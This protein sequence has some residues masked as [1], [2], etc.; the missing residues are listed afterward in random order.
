[1]ER[2]ARNFELAWQET[3]R[4]ERL[5]T[6]SRRHD[7]IRQLERKCGVVRPRR[8]ESVHEPSPTSPPTQTRFTD[9]S[10]SIP[11]RD[12]RLTDSPTISRLKSPRPEESPGAEP[13]AHS[14][15]RGLVHA[16]GGEALA[17]IGAR[18]LS[19]DTNTQAAGS[20]IIST[21]RGSQRS[22]STGRQHQH[23]K[24]SSTMLG[25]PRPLYSGLLSPTNELG[26]TELLGK[27]I[28]ANAR[29]WGNLCHAPS[30]L[31][32]T[33]K[34]EIR[35]K[36]EQDRARALVEKDARVLGIQGDGEESC[37]EV[38]GG[39]KEGGVLADDAARCLQLRH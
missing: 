15:F 8:S 2:E 36:V 20:T 39:G 34:E 27:T 12:F 16:D 7:A 29:S 10:L 28:L 33:N 24:Q 5:D 37:G 26:R 21:F 22:L 30:R 9:S 17:M 11:K 19:E 32:L 13:F 38:W 18:S 4:L 25:F 14:D 6:L 31:R 1:M 23:N 35:R 3:H